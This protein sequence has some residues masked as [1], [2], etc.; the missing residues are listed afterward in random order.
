MA[1]TQATSAFSGSTT[2]GNV[3]LAATGAINDS[4]QNFTFTQPPLLLN[5]NGLLYRQNGGAI[6]WTISGLTVTTSVPVGV[7][8]S[9]F[10]I[11]GILSITEMIGTINDTNISFTSYVQPRY[12]I[13]NG[14]AY[15]EVGATMTWTYNIGTLITNYPVGLNGSLFGLT[16]ITLTVD[17]NGITTAVS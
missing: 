10:G 15:P 14:G 9:I 5:I 6:T 2:V 3:T 17:T 4:N 11:T 13:M 16:G 12:L 7:N 8:G 1:R